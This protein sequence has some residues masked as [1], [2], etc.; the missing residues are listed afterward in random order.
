MNRMMMPEQM[1]A[2]GDEVQVDKLPK[3]LKAMYESGPKGREGV[4]NIAAKTD[5]FA[6]GD[7]VSVMMME[8]END[9]PEMMP[10]SKDI[11]EGLMELQKIQ[12]ETKMLDQFVAQVI[13]MIQA[14]ASEQEVIQMLLQAGLDE[15]DIN[16]V[17]QSVIETLEGVSIDQQIQNLG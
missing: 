6:E 16:A 14:G 11:D 2:E 3:G 10:S 7:E 13:Q 1:M 17:F 5:K 4:E 9:E 8:M 12:P 15:E